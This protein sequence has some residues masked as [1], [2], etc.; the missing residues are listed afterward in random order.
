MGEDARRADEDLIL[1]YNQ[2]SPEFLTFAKG[3][4]VEIQPLPSRGKDKM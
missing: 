4:K 2:S 1:S 3:L